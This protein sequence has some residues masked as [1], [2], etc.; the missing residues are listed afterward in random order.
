MQRKSPGGRLL[1]WSV[2]AAVA[3]AAV[4]AGGCGGCRTPP[5]AT[6][7]PRPHEGAVVRVACPGDAP[8]AVVEG[9]SKGWA[10]R[11]GARVE[12]VRYDPA[13]GPEAGP[14]ADVWVIAPAD[15][16]RHAAVGRLHPVPDAYLA[17][18]AAYA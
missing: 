11:E 15:L 13:R 18:G 3:T 9:Y 10:G 2:A 7:A 16:P 5:A 4:A 6:V 14:A 17:R 1:F 12:V 8:A